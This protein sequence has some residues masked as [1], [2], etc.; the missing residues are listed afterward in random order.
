MQ[1]NIVFYYQIIKFVIIVFSTEKV[2]IFQCKFY[3][4]KSHSTQER[5]KET[6]FLQIKKVQHAVSP[7]NNGERETAVRYPPVRE[8]I[9]GCSHVGT[10]AA[11]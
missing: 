10:R 3:F 11:I 1:K 9:R 7:S 6:Q 8:R 4:K 2:S 5:K